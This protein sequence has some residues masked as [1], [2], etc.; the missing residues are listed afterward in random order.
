MTELDTAAPSP[1][2]KHGTSRSRKSRDQ[3]AKPT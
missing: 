1:A 3:P 2:T